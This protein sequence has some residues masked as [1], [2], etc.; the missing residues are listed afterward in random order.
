MPEG[1]EHPDVPK[2]G[3][4]CSNNQQNIHIRMTLPHKT[5]H[6]HVQFYSSTTTK[7]MKQSS[8]YRQ[9]LSNICMPLGSLGKRP[10]PG[11]LRIN[12]TK[13]ELS[14]TTPVHLQH[15]H[16]IFDTIAELRRASPLHRI[17]QHELHDSSEIIKIPGIKIQLHNADRASHD[18]G[19]V[20]PRHEPPAV[21]KIRSS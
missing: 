7:L 12:D 13:N 6:F 5:I 20:S 16:M 21:R 3:K 10:A 17:G 1:A 8:R 2:I 18:V 9:L 15:V 11:V 19:V 4:W 14:P